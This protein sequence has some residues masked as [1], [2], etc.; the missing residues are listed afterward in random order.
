MSGKGKQTA[1]LH[2]RAIQKRVMP[3]FNTSYLSPLVCL[4]ATADPGVMNRVEWVKF[5]S[6]FFNKE[7]DANQLFNSINQVGRVWVEGG[8]Q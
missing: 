4:S 7:P 1:G 6:L 5:M 3:G 8:V 2:S